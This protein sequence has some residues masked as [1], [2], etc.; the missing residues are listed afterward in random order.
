MVE[1]TTRRGARLENHLEWMLLALAG[2]LLLCA[3]IAQPNA[4][5]LAGL[6][7]GEYAV[8]MNKAVRVC[9]ECIGIG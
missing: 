9:L 1:E 8:T 3:V 2:L 4:S 7:R 6:W 5:L